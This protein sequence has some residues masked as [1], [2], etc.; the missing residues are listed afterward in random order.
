MRIRDEA[1]DTFCYLHYKQVSNSMC[2]CLTGC[3]AAE[4]H[5]GRGDV[6]PHH[7]GYR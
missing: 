5:S 6:T 7:Y 3:G 2:V 1:L 4:Q